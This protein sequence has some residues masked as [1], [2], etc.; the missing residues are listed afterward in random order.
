[1]QLCTANNFI[2]S[3]FYGKLYTDVVRN[4]Q[5][6]RFEYNWTSKTIR[7][8][9]NGQCLQVVTDGKVSG[10]GDVVTAPCDFSQ[11]FQRW[12]LQSGYVSSFHGIFQLRTQDALKQGSLV[13]VGFASST[14]DM[15]N[16]YFGYCSTFNNN[17]VRIVSTRGKRISEYYTGLYFNDPAN[18]FNELFTWD[19]NNKMFKS[20]STDQ[21]L[22]SFL[23]SDGKYKVH[24][25]NCNVNNGNQKWIVHTDTKQ[26]EHA[27]HTGQCLDGD[28]TYLDHHLQM[29]E[30]TPN[31]PNQQWDVI[32]YSP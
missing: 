13:S 3:E 6:E 23:D 31:N 16:H 24:T 4:N 22:D 21:C 32:A 15:L 8:K 1:I 18:N 30:C 28:P 12:E 9:S 27:T 10:L 17:Y 20:V 29:W 2:L 19:A 14:V 26:I 5:N 7:A 25:Y 11:D